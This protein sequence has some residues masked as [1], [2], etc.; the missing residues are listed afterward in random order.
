MTAPVLAGVDVAGDA[1]AWTE[2]GFLVEDAA[3]G[4]G[5][6]RIGHVEFRIGLGSKG[7]AGWTLADEPTVE[8]A[9]HPNGTT[10]LDHIVVFTDDPD[11]TTMSYAELGL[12]ARRVRDVGNGT[13]QTFFRAGEVIVELVGPIPNVTGERCWGLA[14]T[15]ADLDACAV[16][17]G[18]RMGSVKDAV[19]SGRRIATLRHDAV[20][21][22]VPIAFMS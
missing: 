5:R 3:M 21:L 7:I 8:P 9:D 13:T 22:T 4:S 10:V 18:D 17:L 19:Q 20:G 2:A 6:M 11:R 15:V 1:E 12:E 14:M 16:L